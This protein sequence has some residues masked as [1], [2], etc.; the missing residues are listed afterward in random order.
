MMCKIKRCDADATAKGLCAKHYMRARRHGSAKVVNKRGRK[1][2]SISGSIFTTE[3]KEQLK[4]HLLAH[5]NKW[6]SRTFERYWLANKL[7][8]ASVSGGEKKMIA[9]VKSA[10]RPNGSVN[11]SKL[12]RIA[13]EL[14]AEKYPENLI[15]DKSG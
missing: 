11:V 10:S 5:G 15:R 3:D 14:F 1:P 13:A 6:S 8:A 2:G 12:V 9:V 4:A 7:L